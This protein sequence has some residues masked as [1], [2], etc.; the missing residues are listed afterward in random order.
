MNKAR[1]AMIE[2]AQA[3]ITEARVLLEDAAQEEQDYYDNM[4]ESIQA[5]EKGDRAQEAIS[6]L[7]EAVGQLEDVENASLTG[8]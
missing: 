7:E 3:L 1:R 2:K 4:P 5:G 8:E 6:A